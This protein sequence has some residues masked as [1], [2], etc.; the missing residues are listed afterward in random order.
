MLEYHMLGFETLIS[1]GER[2]LLGTLTLLALFVNAMMASIALHV[3]KMP[4]APFPVA[5]HPGFKVPDEH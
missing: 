2:N 3:S 4:P 5:G 1:Y